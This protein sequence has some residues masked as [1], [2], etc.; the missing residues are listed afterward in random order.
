MTADAA[1]P[2]APRAPRP[3]LSNSGSAVTSARSGFRW[4]AAP[5]CP[6]PRYTAVTVS[7]FGGDATAAVGTATGKVTFTGTYPTMVMGAATSTPG[8]A[9]MMPY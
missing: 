3:E 1:T 2:P 6:V 7:S 8:S 5:G 4:P 9:R